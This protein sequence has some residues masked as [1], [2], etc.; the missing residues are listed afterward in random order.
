MGK[1]GEEGFLEA[2]FGDQAYWTVCL[3]WIKAGKQELTSRYIESEQYR[4]ALS[5]T[6]GLL[7]E[8]KQFDDKIILTEVYMLESRAAHAIQNMPRAKVSL[9]FN[10]VVYKSDCVDRIDKCSNYRQFHLLS[11]ITPGIS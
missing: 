5:S 7:K 8:L 3:H 9:H 4:T 2:V 1:I 11:S 6:D 10:R